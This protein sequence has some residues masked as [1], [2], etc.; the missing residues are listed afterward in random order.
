M[1]CCFGLNLKWTHCS[2]GKKICFQ[3]PTY[4]N[5]HLQIFYFMKGLDSAATVLEQSQGAG[6]GNFLTSDSTVN[7]STLSQVIKGSWAFSIFVYMYFLKLKMLITAELQPDDGVH[8]SVLW[9]ICTHYT[10]TARAAFTFLQGFYIKSASLTLC[11]LNPLFLMEIEACPLR[12]H[13]STLNA[14]FHPNDAAKP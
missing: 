5:S 12:Q 6:K 9:S 7:I 8:W 4:L 2:S 14:D 1:F 3:H 13:E 11:R 10:H